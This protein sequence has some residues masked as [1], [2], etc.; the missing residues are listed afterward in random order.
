MF[1]ESFSQNQ[2]VLHEMQAALLHNQDRRDYLKSLLIKP[3]LT[4]KQ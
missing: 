2:Q 4:L 3:Y 1:E